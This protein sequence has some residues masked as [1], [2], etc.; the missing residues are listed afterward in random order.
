VQV[1][2]FDLRGTLAHFRR[3]DT[4][5]THASYPFITRTAL[6]GLLAAVLGL[7]EWRGEAWTG[8]RLL[9]QPRT[10]VQQ[11][12]LLG[13]FFLE[14]GGGEDKALNRPTSVELVVRP[15]YRIYFTG[16]HLEEL[17]DRIREGRSTYHTYLG[18]AFALT[19]PAF[20]ALREASDL[21]LQPGQLV[22]TM[23]VVPVHVIDELRGL[24]DGAQYGRAGGM[25]YE[26]LGERRFQ[27]TI[28]L[29]Y[30]VSGNR[31]LSFT[32]R[33]GQAAPPVRIVQ[34]VQGETAALW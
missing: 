10:R 9:A 19:F 14:S 17:T 3:P 20:V 21:I 2:V 1:L 26:H 11:M 23:T 27:G 18:S 24:R 31:P 33:E 22:E 8:L 13:K 15:H 29:I 30:E 12:S 32:W 5:S 34:L 6:R 28:N 16:D 25:L 4:T 7:D